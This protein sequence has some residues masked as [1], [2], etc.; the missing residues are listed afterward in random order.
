M[1][2]SIYMKTLKYI[3]PLWLFIALFLI[4]CGQ[5]RN[6]QEH[7]FVQNVNK[8]LDWPEDGGY[9]DEVMQSVFDY[10]R[11]NPQSLD[12]EF[13]DEP[14]RMRIA[15]SGDSLV[16]A[17]SLK[18]IPHWDMIVKQFFNLGLEKTC[19]VKNLTT[20]MDLLLVF[21]ILIPI[22]IYWK[23]FKGT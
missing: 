5:N 15:T 16:R 11:K 17:Y 2:N 18:V 3:K 19:S 4:S 1:R 8:M 23:L 6:R 10:I 9:S 21:I 13:E 7:S 20:L 14:S 12:Y 22:I